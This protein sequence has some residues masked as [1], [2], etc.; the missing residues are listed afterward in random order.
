VFLDEF[1]VEPRM[2]TEVMALQGDAS[3]NVP[4]VYNIGEKRALSLVSRF[5]KIENVFENADKVVGV[6]Y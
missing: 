5:G 2:W 3:D 1:G 4:G 6:L